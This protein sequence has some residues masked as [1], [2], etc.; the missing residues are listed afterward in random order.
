[1]RL[2]PAD[3]QKPGQTLEEHLCHVNGAANEVRPGQPLNVRNVG[4]HTQCILLVT[5][6]ALGRE[7]SVGV[8]SAY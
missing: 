1:M 5:S 7:G 6:K 2:H 4:G 3:H 8:T